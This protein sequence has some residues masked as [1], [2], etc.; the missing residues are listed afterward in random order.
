[1]RYAATKLLLV[2]VTAAVLAACGTRQ[3]LPHGLH[4]PHDA[5]PLITTALP[6]DATR[7]VDLHA[8]PEL[9]SLLPRLADNKV[10]FIGETHDR[11]E[12]HLNQLEIIRGLH[13]NGVSLAIGCECFQQPYQ[14]QLDA[15]VVGEIDEKALLRRSEY[16]SRWGHDYRLYR[17]IMEYARAH[18]IPVVALSVASE[19]TQKVRESGW[20]SLTPQD[21]IE[22]ATLEA[23]D[24]AYRTR[25]R[26]AF[27]RHPWEREADFERFVQVHGLWESAMAKG[28]ADYVSAHP[29]RKL[30]ALLGAAH[31]A[32]GVGVP[33]RFQRYSP[34]TYAIVL[35]DPVGEE[36]SPNVADFL[37]LTS[38]RDL[39]PLGRM[40]VSL[41][42]AA[43][44][45]RVRMLS[46]DGGAAQ[47]GVERNDT[48]I[49]LD[50]VT[51]RN[52]ADLNIAMLDKQPGATVRVTVRRKS[53]LLQEQVMDMDVVLQ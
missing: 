3:H 2:A 15:Y 44:G 35:I 18:R 9:S 1:M 14:A 20:S 41:E 49:A 16:Y 37:L 45:V 28:A 50:G 5:A 38:P 13:G 4:G 21:G 34:A 27:N 39:P 7:V 30:V 17:P 8:L 46:S 19:V 51:I 32:Q 48:L 22:P 43:D 31:V 40:G 24:A 11:L 25:L 10:I 36:L 42:A 26:A 53:W 47:A 12:H 23:P 33:A 29:E 6:A 52:L